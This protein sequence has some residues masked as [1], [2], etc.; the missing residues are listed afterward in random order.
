[1]LNIVS[2]IDNTCQP[3]LYRGE[4]CMKKFVKQLTEIKKNIFKQI[5]INKPMDKLTYDQ[6]QNLETRPIALYVIKN[7]T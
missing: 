2:R 6:K 4:D 1:M 7:S 3:Y 5:N